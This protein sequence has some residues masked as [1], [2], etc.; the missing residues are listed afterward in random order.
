M[1][2]PFSVQIL[3]FYRQNPHEEN[4]GKIGGANAPPTTF[5]QP[6]KRGFGRVSAARVWP[7][8]HTLLV[9]FPAFFCCFYIQLVFSFESSIVTKWPWIL[10][11]NR[12]ILRG[13]FS[14]G[15]QPLDFA[16]I[17]RVRINS[18]L[19]QDLVGFW[20]QFSSLSFR[21]GPANKL[22]I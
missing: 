8:G 13:F 19:I 11:F 6:R 10:G 16:L 21:N 12:S 2:V 3:A 9:D 17:H 7:G 20:A 14:T 4:H 15:F 18:D 1:V 5:K 22:N